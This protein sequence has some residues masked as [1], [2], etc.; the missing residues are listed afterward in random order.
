MQ[1]KRAQRIE[2]CKP[3]RTTIQI[4]SPVNTVYKPVS[5][6]REERE[7]TK[8]KKV[9][10][11]KIRMS[12]DESEAKLYEAF[13][14]HQYYSF[15]DLQSITNQPSAFLSEVLKSICVYGKH[16]EHPHMW[17]LREEYRH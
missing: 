8:R 2:A 16:P 14:K 1:L 12:K 13:E 15:K 17:E 7:D 10:G 6:T 4:K 3:V 5:I 11:K 9:E